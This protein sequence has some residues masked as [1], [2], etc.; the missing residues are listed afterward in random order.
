MKYTVL[1]SLLHVYQACVYHAHTCVYAG[2]AG[3][4]SPFADLTLEFNET[5]STLIAKWIDSS[6]FIDEYLINYTGTV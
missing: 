6:L 1:C 3:G 4:I 5:L 2:S